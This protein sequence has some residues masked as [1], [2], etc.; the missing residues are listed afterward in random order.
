MVQEIQRNTPK[1][2][3]AIR[4]KSY[5]LLGIINKMQGNFDLAMKNQLIALKYRKLVG[6]GEQIAGSY[7][8]LGIL[9]QR[10][11]N[12]K[13]AFSYLDS[14][15]VIAKRLK[16]VK[17][18]VR[19]KLSLGNLWQQQD[20][21]T[22]KALQCY[23]QSLGYLKMQPV[24]TLKRMA[25]MGIANV[26][27][28]INNIDSA[29]YYYR[30]LNHYYQNKNDN[31]F[32]V[33]NYTNLG[34]LFSQNNNLDS[35]TLYL[36]KAL[37]LGN[38]MGDVNLIAI[39]RINL[40]DVY[41][42]AGKMDE[43][44]RALVPL[45]SNSAGLELDNMRLVFESLSNYFEKTG[46]FDSALVYYKKYNLLRDS[47]NKEEKFNQVQELQAQFNNER[48]KTE[49]LA[50]EQE[51][52]KANV[53]SGRLMTITISLVAVLLIAILIGI[54]YRIRYRAKL[55]LAQK[56]EE[57]H[58]QKLD[59]IFKERQIEKMTALMEGQERERSRIAS[60]L[61]D[62]IGMLLATIKHH[63][64]MIEDEMDK[65]GE[66]YK[67]AFHLLDK[68]SDEVRRISHNMASSVLVKFGLAAA[69][70]DLV[71]TISSSE[72]L[73]IDLK[74]IGITERLENSVEIHVFR[75]VQE[76]LGNILKHAKATKVTVQLVM[77]E[78]ELMLMVEDN[79]VGF[80]P[81]DG[82][83]FKGMGLSN[84]EARVA[85]LDGKLE[86]DSLSGKG[87]TIIITIPK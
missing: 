1:D 53:R 64:Q 48:L 27:N 17:Y 15:W 79:G 10:T 47:I 52:D 68:A 12:Y 86:I 41:S 74:L 29:A 6:D 77:H 62:G 33:A 21:N 60:E 58:K 4:G 83:K 16:S 57:L 39:I 49:K 87:T 40:C 42:R 30:L 67:K 24:E 46:R 72:K 7:V 69:L 78:S 19:V 82:A 63:F 26:H 84:M 56:N 9:K 44:Y 73:H 65:N 23:W 85:H 22:E 81:V 13:D 70:R 34:V 35:A 37:A 14:A 45:V 51:R 61:H 66:V 25:L 36:Q 32:L 59:E 38:K 50:I 55:M 71:E 18:M 80:N 2:N 54:I 28:R 75:T 76:L 20:G 3:Y 11:S 5:A 8:N 43:S 31:Y